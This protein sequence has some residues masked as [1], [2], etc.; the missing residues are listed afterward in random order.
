MK[1]RCTTLASAT[2]GETLD[3]S[4]WLTVG[5]T[6]EVLAMSATVGGDIFLRLI[7]DD[8]HTPGL[9]SAALF[10]SV[11]ET[12]PG[13]WEARIDSQGRLGIAPASW[14]RRGFWE[15]FFNGVPTA[16]EAFDHA[17]TAILSATHQECSR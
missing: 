3:K 1:A 11:D 4:A 13:I 2:T 15:D 14:L 17:R 7:G 12:M 9:F 10:E 6:Y 16:L 8:G 5:R